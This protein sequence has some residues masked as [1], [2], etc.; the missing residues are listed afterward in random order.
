MGILNLT[1]DSFSDG[2]K[3][4]NEKAALKRLEEMEKQGAN[5]IDIGGESTGPNSP[6]VSG[7]EEIGRVLPILK[8]IRKYTQLPISIDTYKAEV[9]YQCL[10]EG[11]DLINDVTALRQNPKLAK[12]VAKAKCP[13]ILMY[14]KDKTP[15]TT[16]E[17]THYKDVIK[18]IKKFLEQRI[19]FAKKQGI[20]SENIII[21]PGMG[22][23]VS[24]IPKY[25]LE[26][27][28]RL[29]ELQTLKY[30][31]LIGISRK[32]FLEGSVET[33]DTKGALL[34]AIA[35]LNGASIIRTHN[36]KTTKECLKWI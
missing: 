17:E 28:A 2:G 20:A 33:R 24:A 35:Y 36:I 10:E 32:S 13:I 27:I 18:A 16:R 14:S 31:I 8:I 34:E 3:F 6:A 11:A 7:R 4:N 23:F 5:I 29:K 22:A 9:A 12:I 19:K 21:D 15:R 25:S 30:P 26:I 1:P